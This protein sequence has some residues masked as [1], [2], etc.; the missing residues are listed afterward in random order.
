MHVHTQNHTH[1]QCFHSRTLHYWG[2]VLG[3]EVVSERREVQCGWDERIA[4]FFPLSLIHNVCVWNI[5]DDKSHSRRNKVG[6]ELM[7]HLGLDL[8]FFERRDFKATSLSLSL[9]LSV[10]PSLS[11]CVWLYVCLCLLSLLFDCVIKVIR[12]SICCN[13]KH[14][15]KSH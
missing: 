9:H 13:I 12:A 3:W 15:E 11:L 7:C 2:A 4:C 10:P 5:H 6:S 1:C 8:S 14:F